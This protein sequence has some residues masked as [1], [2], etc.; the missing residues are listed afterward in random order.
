MKRLTILAAFAMLALAPMAAAQVYGDGYLLS[1]SSIQHLDDKGTFTMLYNN[2]SYAHGVTMDVDNKNVLFAVGDV[3]RLDPVTSMV[4]TLTSFGFSTDGNLVLDHNGDYLFTGNDPNSGWGLYRISGS[5]VTTIVTT[6]SMGLNAQPTGGLLRD[7]DDGH[8]VMQLYGGPLPGIQPMISVAPDGTF[9]TVVVNLSTIY[10]PRYEF[11]QDIV[12]GDYYVGGNGNNQGVLFQVAK[13]GQATV[14]A[15]SPNDPYAFNTVAADRSSAA[16]RRLVHPY[17]R[18]LY[19]TDL[20]T[21][22][23][24]SVAVNGSSVSPRCIDFYKGRN[25]QTVLNSPGKYTVRYSFPNH[26]GKT[27][28]AAM[29]YS[30]VRPGVLLPDGRRIMLNPDSLTV[31]TVANQLPQLFNPGPGILDSNGEAQGT[32]NVS[33]LPP[34]GMPVHVIAVVLD[35][36]APQGFAVIADPFVMI[37]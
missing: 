6:V 15:T 36:A 11:T 20:K 16:N 2:P 3:F 37:I 27:Y 12:T 30:G 17:I 32:I 33:F 1:G 22:T 18:N 34:L 19:Y 5:T 26:P 7:I 10:T 21:F 29:G 31:V 24:T 13:N 23:V 35:P 25:I 28:V 8:Y 14:I 4:T 9:T